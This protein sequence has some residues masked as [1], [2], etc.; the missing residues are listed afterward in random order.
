[1]CAY[2]ENPPAV[3]LSPRGARASAELS[4]RFANVRVCADNQEV[5]DHASMVIVAVHP[6]DRV[7]ALTGLRL[8]DAREVVS[9]MAGVAIDGAR[10]LLGTRAPVVRVIPLPAVRERG[11][12]AVTCP[13]HSGVDTVFE[14]PGGVLPVPDEATLDVFQTLTSTLST[15]Y[16]YLTTFTE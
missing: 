9:A 14:R 10:T 6:Q 4:R 16:R 5:L 1:M 2:V 11:S 7:A 15:H 12:V 8:P 13:R 3:L